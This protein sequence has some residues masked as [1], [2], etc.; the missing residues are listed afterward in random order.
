MRADD[1]GRAVLTRVYYLRNVRL[2][3]TV[4]RQ[5]QF[6]QTGEYILLTGLGARLR[7]VP[8]ECLPPPRLFPL[9]PT[10]VYALAGGSRSLNNVSVLFRCATP[11]CLLV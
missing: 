7:T 5:K 4:V 3:A 2:S 11:W 8:G 9:S 10:L 1:V 6:P